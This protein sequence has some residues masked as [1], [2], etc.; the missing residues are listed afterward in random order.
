MQ[1]KHAQEECRDYSKRIHSGGTKSGGLA[2][3]AGVILVI[4]ASL[5]YPG[6]VLIDPVDS[7]EFPALIAAMSDNASITHVATLSVPPATGGVNGEA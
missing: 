3:I 2:L 4:F 1:A 7:F 6:G 5:F